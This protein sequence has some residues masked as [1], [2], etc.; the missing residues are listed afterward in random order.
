MFFPA[1]SLKSRACKNYHFIFSVG[2]SS[3]ESRNIKLVNRITFII[4]ESKFIKKKCAVK[5]RLLLNFVS[6]LT[7]FM[8]YKH[9][10]IYSYACIGTLNISWSSLCPRNEVVGWYTGFTMSVRLSVRPTVCPSVCR[11]ILCRTIT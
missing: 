7:N 9:C 10:C 4:E 3:L 6:K 2:T 1:I 5:C 8:Y 11:Q